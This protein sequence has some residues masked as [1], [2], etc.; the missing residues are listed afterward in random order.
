MIQSAEFQEIGPITINKGATTRVNINI[1][2]KDLSSEEYANLAFVGSDNPQFVVYTISYSNG[3]VVVGV[4][5]ESATVGQEYVVKAVFAYPANPSP[6]KI[7]TTN[8]LK[9]IG[10]DE[11]GQHD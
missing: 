8:T 1:T 9:I 4:R 10:G 5:N 11:N 7:F 6:F 2:P 3:V